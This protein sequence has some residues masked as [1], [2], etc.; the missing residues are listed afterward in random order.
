[1]DFLSVSQ[2]ITCTSCIRYSDLMGIFSMYTRIS[3]CLPALQSIRWIYTTFSQRSPVR[4]IMCPNWIA[5]IPCRGLL[6]V[7]RLRIPI[8]WWCRTG[9]ALANQLTYSIK[10]NGLQAPLYHALRSNRRNARETR[11]LVHSDTSPLGQV[12]IG[13]SILSTTAPGSNILRSI[14]LLGWLLHWL[15]E[16]IKFSFWEFD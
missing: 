9:A 15:I 11:A 6:G 7:L 13:Y 16:G 1:M 3:P 14:M 4:I 10:H 8:M 5:P 12:M 2:T